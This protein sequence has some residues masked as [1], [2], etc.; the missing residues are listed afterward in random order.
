MTGFLCVPPPHKAVG[1]KD[2][3]LIINGVQSHREI[4]NV[5]VCVPAP[6]PQVLIS[7]AVAALDV[8]TDGQLDKGSDKQRRKEASKAR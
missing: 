6:N 8:P 3:I 1:S 2:I 5:G 7:L 4:L